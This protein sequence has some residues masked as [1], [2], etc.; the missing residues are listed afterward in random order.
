VCRAL[1]APAELEVHPA[2]AVEPAATWADTTRLGRALGFV[3]VTDL[4]E[5]VARQVATTP[6]PAQ[7][8]PARPEPDRLEPVLV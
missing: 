6:E 3:P 1:G 2:A 5:L 8:D 4:D 7:P